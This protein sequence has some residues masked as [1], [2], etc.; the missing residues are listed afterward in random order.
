MVVL[1][2]ILM[3]LVATYLLYRGHVENNKAKLIIA[4]ILT[5][6]ALGVLYF[7]TGGNL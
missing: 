1:I 3:V 2:A 4:L 7:M 6:G 5:L